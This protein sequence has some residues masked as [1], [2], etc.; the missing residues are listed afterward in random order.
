M[1]LSFAFLQHVATLESLRSWSLPDSQLSLLQS[2]AQLGKTRK[3][4]GEI[5]SELRL[6]DCL[7]EL[8]KEKKKARG[9]LGSGPLVTN[10]PSLVGTS[11]SSKNKKRRRMLRAEKV[12]SA[13]RS[14]K[15]VEA[16][17][18]DGE[19][20]SSSGSDIWEEQEDT[21]QDL[22]MESSEAV[23]NAELDETGPVENNSGVFMIVQF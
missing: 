7:Q 9:E 18:L 13:P 20:D 12:A 2:S 21:Q 3:T 16:E 1:Y 17:G 6:K 11:W 4:R 15:D 23:E 5:L 8:S 14:E 10:V 19:S 22:W